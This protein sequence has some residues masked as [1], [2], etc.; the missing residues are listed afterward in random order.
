MESDNGKL[1]IGGISWETNEDRLREYFGSFGEV[2]EAVI[3]K[4]RSTGRARGFGF[5]VFAD[6]T[7]AERVVVEK[8][9]IDGRLVEAKKAVPRDGQHTLNK[10]TSSNHGSPS[11]GRTRKIFVGGLASTVTEADFKKYF[12]QFGTIID[13]VVMYDHNT[14][15]PRG[16]G[17]ITYDSED[18]VD[19]ALLKTFHELNGKMVEVKRAVPKEMSPGPNMRSPIGE[20]NSPYARFN[21][22]LNGY[23]QGYTPSP[24]GGY[25]T[26]VDGR[27]GLLAGGRNGYPPVGLNYGNGTNFEPGVNHSFGGTSTFS[28]SLSYGRQQSPYY[29]GSSSR[30]NTNTGYGGVNDNAG[31]VFSSLARN[32][33]GNGSLNYATNIASSNAFMPS[34]SGSLG[35]FGNEIVNWGG[36]SSPSSAHGMGSGSGYASRYLGNDPENKNFGLHANS[37]G[38]NSGVSTVNTSFT[39]SRNV[40]EGNYA[41]SFGSNSIY[42][43]TAWKSAS[44]E[45]DGP[46]SYGLGNADSDLIP[47]GSESYL[48]RYN[49]TNSQANGGLAANEIVLSL[50]GS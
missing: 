32:I 20:H 2:M 9:M 49:A 15:R 24:I 13:V 31:S 41:D 44:S 21:S 10:N 46:F 19:K 5:I 4:D 39:V 23:T 33:W 43:H 27:F 16:F 14:Q 1:F 22:F 11:P 35:V 26:R 30:Y 3:M 17:F 36:L 50:Q 29:N 7:V 6:P 34:G 48:A 42:G 25:G 8:H 18:A 12:D 28:N 40:N 38:R 37:Y 47:N 45:L